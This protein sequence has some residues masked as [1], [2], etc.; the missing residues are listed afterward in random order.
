MRGDEWL[1]GSP[2]WL[3]GTAGQDSAYSLPFPFLQLDFGFFSS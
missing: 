3:L 1:P 2:G